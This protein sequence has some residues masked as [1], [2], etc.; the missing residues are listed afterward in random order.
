[1]SII[2]DLSELRTEL[3]RSRGFIRGAETQLSKTL[4]VL[5]SIEV[6]AEEEEP[7]PDPEPEPS[8]FTITG[9]EFLYPDE[10]NLEAL[11]ESDPIRWVVVAWGSDELP[12]APVQ[13]ADDT[14][15]WVNVAIVNRD[16]EEVALQVKPDPLVQDN[17][18]VGIKLSTSNTDII[19]VSEVILVYP[20]PELPM[21][22]SVW[23]GVLAE[24][25]TPIATPEPT[26]QPQFEALE[27]GG[28]RVSWAPST[29]ANE[30]RLE[31]AGGDIYT[32]ETSVEI[33]EMEVGEWACV[34]A[35][36]ESGES[37]SRC[38]TWNESP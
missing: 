19:E 2:D 20:L 9:V 24:R 5:D 36:N 4:E 22:T 15:L 13:L 26:G 14:L 1:M 18:D 35:L 21:E 38:N 28:A 17:L 12:Y 11:G 33:P 8:P 30:Y 3:I 32:S 34:Y 7:T 25:R 31:W 23:L 27:T 37:G 16:T 10:V 29:L 6:P